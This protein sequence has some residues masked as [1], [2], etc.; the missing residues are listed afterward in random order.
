MRNCTATQRLRN[1]IDLSCVDRFVTE[2]DSDVNFNVLRMIFLRTQLCFDHQVCFHEPT[3]N[4]NENHY[5][6]TQAWLLGIN[7]QLRTNMY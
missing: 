7:S 3:W 2:Y 4:Y 6:T 5:G 1:H